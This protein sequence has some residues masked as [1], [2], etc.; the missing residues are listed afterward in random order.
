[1]ESNR[2]GFFKFNVSLGSE[3]VVITSDFQNVVSWFLLIGELWRH[4]S[5]SN[6]FT[7][8]VLFSQVPTKR[9]QQWC[10]N[11]NNIPY[12]ETSAKEA[13]NVEQAFQTIAKNV[14]A[15]ESEQDVYNEFP[16]QIKLPGDNRPNN[17]DAGCTC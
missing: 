14:L 1:M 4:V 11:K 10:Q 12:F 17:N 5:S 2:S 3:C 15:L 7:N 6:R 8:V 9:A 16:D 13:I